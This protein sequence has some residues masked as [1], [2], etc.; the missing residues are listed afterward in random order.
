MDYIKENLILLE[1]LNGRVGVK[2]MILVNVIGKY[3]EL[4]KNNNR[5]RIIDF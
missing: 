5:L 1:N 4:V 3:G 2:E